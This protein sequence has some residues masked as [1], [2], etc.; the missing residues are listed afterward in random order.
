MDDLRLRRSRHTSQTSYNSQTKSNWK[1]R[2]SNAFGFGKGR[3][4]KVVPMEDLRKSFKTF[5][6][7]TDWLKVIGYSD[8]D[9]NAMLVT[10]RCWQFK[11][12]SDRLIML[13]IF[14]FVLDDNVDIN[15]SN[16]SPI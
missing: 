1:R 13:E 16:M 2:M 5:S 6:C 8:V 10:L 9:D 11:S 15:I 4:Q 3:R 7:S 12:V 14:S